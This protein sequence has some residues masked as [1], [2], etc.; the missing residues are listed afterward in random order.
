MREFLKRCYLVFLRF[1]S[2]F[3]S[4]RQDENRVLFLTDFP[5]TT[6]SIWQNLSDLDYKKVKLSVREVSFVKQLKEIK[7]AKYI[8]ADNY[9]VLFTIANTRD[10]VVIQTWHAGGAIKKIGFLSNEVQQHSASRKKRYQEVYDSF[11]YYLCASEHMKETFINS[12]NQPQEKMLM[13]GYPKLDCYTKIKYNK[14]VE[15]IVQNRAEQVEK[16]NILYVPTFRDEESDN[17]E[18]IE[19]L[20]YLEQNLGSEY[21]IFYK[22]H[23]ELQKNKSITEELKNL[24]SCIQIGDGLLEYYYKIADIMISDY[25]SAIFEYSLFSNRII[26]YPYDYEKY[27]RERGLNVRLEEL[28]PNIC[29]TH[30]EL[31]ESVQSIDRYED[32][33][34]LQGKFQFYNENMIGRK[35]VEALFP[36]KEVKKVRENE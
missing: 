27:Y 34:I 19:V 29:R 6:D 12:F 26:L 14:K 15:E 21:N 10:K 35:V 9:N 2:L 33:S 28:T 32:R 7:K 4:G 31:L 22:L 23:P 16:M 5:Y 36:K 8:F 18:Q 17:L 24:T 20:K 30:R 11:D 1:R 3:M 25:S 13:L